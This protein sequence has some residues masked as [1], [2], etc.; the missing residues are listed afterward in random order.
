MA[1]EHAV[2][3]LE[4][5]P[6]WLGR[7]LVHLLRCIYFEPLQ[8]H[9]PLM[10]QVAT[11]NLFNLARV[12]LDSFLGDIKAKVLNGLSKEGAPAGL[13]LSPAY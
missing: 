11:N 7:Q 5:F 1:I 13:S 6:R 4:L 3:A 12:C 10:M 9:N 2:K 8:W